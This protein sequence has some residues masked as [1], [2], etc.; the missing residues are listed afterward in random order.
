MNIIEIWSMLAPMVNNHCMEGTARSGLSRQALDAISAESGGMLL[1]HRMQDFLPFYIS[2]SVNDLLDNASNGLSAASL[3]QFVSRQAFP[4]HSIW[5]RFKAHMDSGAEGPACTALLLSDAQGRDRWFCGSY[6]RLGT[7]AQGRVLAMALFFDMEHLGPLGMDRPE[8]PSAIGVL[9]KRL[10][11][12]S[13]REVEV[14]QLI[15]TEHSP[16][17]IARMLHLSVNTVHSHRKNLVQK[18]E[19]RSTL[20]LAVYLPLIAQRQSGKS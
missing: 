2:P 19:V 15:V 10:E 16:A 13:D 14:L 9:R 3:L 7:D 6:G 18:L 8:R 4:V 11:G 17:Q 1:V 12:L 5:Q 20:G